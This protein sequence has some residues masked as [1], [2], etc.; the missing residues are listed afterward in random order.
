VREVQQYGRRRPVHALEQ[1]EHLHSKPLV[2]GAEGDRAHALEEIVAVSLAPSSCTRRLPSAQLQ[3]RVAIQIPLA[4][5]LWRNHFLDPPFLFIDRVCRGPVS[6]LPFW[7]A[8]HEV[9]RFPAPPQSI[10]GR[11]LRHANPVLLKA[12]GSRARRHENTNPISPWRPE[13]PHPCLACLF[14]V[15]P[16]HRRQGSFRKTIGCGS[17]PIAS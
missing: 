6:D 1:D 5:T 4:L 15:A 13:P 8:K 7:E 17:V 14:S 16:P 2:R 3:E 9:P 10:T 11:L 12:S